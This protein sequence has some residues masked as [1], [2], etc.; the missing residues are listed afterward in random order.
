MQ[1]GDKFGL[2]TLLE[3]I[4]GG[5]YWLCQC[6]CGEQTKASKWHLL[7]GKR[8]ACGCRQKPKITHYQCLKCGFEK[9]RDEFYLRKNGR[10]F[11]RICKECKKAEIRLKSKQYH[12]TYRLAALEHY[13]GNPPQ[14]E[15]CGE[16]TIEFLHLDHKNGDGNEHRKKLKTY[17]IY[18]WLKRH[19]YPDIG[20]RV[21]C[22]NCNL[23]LG[24]YGYCPHQEQC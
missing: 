8:K 2:L 21:L 6:D 23:S 4:H 18:R 3:P 22:A 9:P 12:R 10:L 15:C 17:N 20:L 5:K 7:H 14:C 16:S 13:G 19:N 11:H 1:P 24:A